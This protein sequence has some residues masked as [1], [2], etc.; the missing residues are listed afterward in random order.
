MYG[1]IPDR[2]TARLRILVGAALAVGALYVFFV[3]YVSV[4]G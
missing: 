1:D 4:F 3:G 2:P